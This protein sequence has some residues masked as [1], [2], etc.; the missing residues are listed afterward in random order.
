M[1]QHGPFGLE[2]APRL[3]E[4]GYLDTEGVHSSKPCNSQATL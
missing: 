3:V 2:A 1:N 4:L